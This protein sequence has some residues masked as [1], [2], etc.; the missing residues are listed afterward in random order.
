MYLY[1]TTIFTFSV[2][3]I[4]GGVFTLMDVTLKPTFIRKYKVQPETNEPIDNVK[5]IRAIKVILFNQI[6]VGVPLTFISY[7]L[8]MLKGFPEDFRDVPDF[9]R[10]LIDLFVCILIDEI[11]FYY[12]HS[13]LR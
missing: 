2:Y 6:I 13:T 3:W 11:G 9:S 5:L 7:Y 12:S 10:V 1:A 8:K 4:F